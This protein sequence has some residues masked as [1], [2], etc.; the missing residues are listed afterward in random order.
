MIEMGL[1]DVFS[2]VH[3]VEKK[4]RDGTFENGSK[5][6]DIVLASEGML[7]IVEGKKLIEWNKIIDYDHRDFLKDINLKEYFD[8]EFNQ[9]NE[10]ERNGW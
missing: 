10:R 5:C 1:L 2:E 7:E 3:D 6:I 8:E 4:N 9:E